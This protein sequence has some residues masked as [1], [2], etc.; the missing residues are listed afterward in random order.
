MRA[1]NSVVMKRINRHMILNCIR[2]KPISRA[3]LS[4]ET[5]LTRAS[6][7]LIID[8]L[9]REGLVMESAEVDNHRPGRRKTQL[10]LVH[11]A[12]CVAGIRFTK[13]SYD[14]GL[15]RLNGEVLWEK[16]CD[17]FGRKSAEIM[18][19]AARLLKNAARE[20]SVNRVYGVGI[21]TPSPLEMRWSKNFRGTVDPEM[22]RAFVAAEMQKRLNWDV[23]LGNI[24][25][26]YAL[27]EFYFGAGK[28]G[29]ENFMV[30]RVDDSVGAGFIINGNLFV[31]VRGQSP[32]IGHITLERDGALCKC[33][34]RG[35]MELY[36]AMPHV[37]KNTPF[38]T[39]K[40]VVDGVDEDSLARKLFENEAATLAFGIVNLANVMELDR[41]IIS[42]D[43]IYGGERMAESVNRYM[44]EHFVYRMNPSSVVCGKEI[45]ISRIACMPAYHSIFA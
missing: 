12:M 42:G 38:S 44:D 32:E 36:L 1:I 28:D 27:D 41:V 17:F 4:D 31:G 16:H 43:L 15:M 40:E 2:R 11:D 26:A 25:N 23:Y 5:R 21:C 22:Q 18:D 10:T 14:M 45:N 33:G 39:W 29:V 20:L 9:I 13:D 8:S 3:E 34:N 35:C 6:I 24:T 7:T 30:L 37:L 19:E